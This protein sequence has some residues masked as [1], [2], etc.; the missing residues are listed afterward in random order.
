MSIDFP[1]PPIRR[2]PPPRGPDGPAQAGNDSTTRGSDPPGVR[3]QERRSEPAYSSDPKKRDRLDARLRRELP[4]VR[5]RQDGLWP[6]LLIR[7]HLG[8]TGQRPILQLILY[9]SPDIMM[10]EGDVQQPNQGPAVS[11]PRIGHDHTVFVHV[12]NLGK[13]AAIGANLSVYL[14]LPAATELQLLS[15]TYFN[16]PDVRSADCHQTIRLPK[17]LRPTAAG[18]ITLFA[19]VD[20]L[21]DPC[22]PD[23]NDRADRHVARRSFQVP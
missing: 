18:R 19:R 7:T 11:T 16:L 15:S 9:E 21:F 4:K 23:Y 6:F 8:D 22:G 13:L 3:R 20:S 5:V 12:W 17:L 1:I 2:V 14:S 10:I